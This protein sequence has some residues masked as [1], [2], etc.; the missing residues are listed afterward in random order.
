MVS[1]SLSGLLL[2]VVISTGALAKSPF[3]DCAVRTGQN[4]SIFLRA[5]VSPTVNGLTLEPGDEV[6][7]LDSEGTC[8]GK[9]VWQGETVAVSVWGDD[10]MTP[11]KDG[12]AIGERIRFIVFDA[13]E[14]LIYGL[15]EG[16]ATIDFEQDF[17]FKGDGTYEP[18]AL[19]NI[20]YFDV[21]S[22]PTTPE[23]PSSQGFTITPPA[24]NPFN[25]AT[26][27]T[28]SLEDP[29]DVAIRV[30]NA[31]GRQVA[32]IHDGLLAAGVQHQFRFDGDLLPSG[33][34][35]FRVRGESFATVK[36]V[37]LLK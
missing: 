1:R 13:S 14:N 15:E 32:T 3:V 19:Y 27:F 22:E 23:A 31:L 7:A 29:Q 26:S 24:P 9:A 11:A 30:Y 8:V 20:A 25:P 12:L 6:V 34:Y 21:R 10:E 2:A 4:A 18:D 35:V 33:V 5:D 28:L 17:P 37:V 36:S 16:T